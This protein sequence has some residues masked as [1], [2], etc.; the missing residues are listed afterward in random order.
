MDPAVLVPAAVLV[1][2]FFGAKFRAAAVVERHMSWACN[3]NVQERKQFF[4]N[5]LRKSRAGS[6][7][8]EIGFFFNPNTDVTIKGHTR[9]HFPPRPPPLTFLLPCSPPLV[10]TTLACPNVYESY[11][12]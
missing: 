7:E 8:V 11:G 6:D 3:I 12:L 4:V 5:A 10:S 9:S 2:V 1:D